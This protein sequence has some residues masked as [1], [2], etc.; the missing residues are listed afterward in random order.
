MDRRTQHISPLTF[1]LARPSTK[2]GSPARR[3][4]AGKMRA[5]RRTSQ[6]S[7]TYATRFMKRVPFDV[8]YYCVKKSGLYSSNKLMRIIINIQH[9]SRL[10]LPAVA[11]SDASQ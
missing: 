7:W 11:M 3:A 6:A 9:L 5:N 10:V 4:S 2:L 1:L 8:P